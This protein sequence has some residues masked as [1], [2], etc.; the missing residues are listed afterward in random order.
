M[1]DLVFRNELQ[2]ATYDHSFFEKILSVGVEELGTQDKNVEV[3]VS[4]IGNERSRELNQQHRGKDKPTNVLSFP[5]DDGAGSGDIFICMPVAQ[6]E[7]ER[8]GVSLADRLA[9]LTV[10]GFLHLN[11]YD[12]ELSEADAERMFA[13]EKQI[14]NKCKF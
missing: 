7:A 6:E 11:G 9:W 8:D 14:L 13:L 10:H 3:S 5:L 4:L 2:E 1:L 12:H